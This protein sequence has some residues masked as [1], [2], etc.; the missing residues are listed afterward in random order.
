[1]TRLI[2]S[3]ICLAVLSPVA[4]VSANAGSANSGGATVVAGSATTTAW[5]AS[6]IATVTAHGIFPGT[7]ASFDP[8]APLE[9]GDL[10]LALEQLGAASIAAAAPSTPVSIAAL[11]A[12]VV[13]ALGLRSAARA[14]TL[15]ADQAGLHPPSR[16]GTEVVARLL[17][18]RTNLPA[19]E[20]S[21]ELQPQQ[22]ATRADAAFSLARVLSLGLENA[23]GTAPANTTAV[24]AADAGAGVQWLK[25][26]AASFVLPALTSQQAEVLQTAVSLIGFPYVWG[27]DNEKLEPGFDCSGLVWRVFKLASYADAPALSS[28]FQGRTA[29]AMAFEV[30]K[31][32]RIA[33]A[34]LEPGDV[35]FFGAGP[36][37]TR[38]QIDHSSIYL[39]NGWLIQAS[40]QGVSLG[41]LAWQATTF[42]WARR[43]LAESPA[44]AGAAGTPAAGPGPVLSV[45][46]A[47]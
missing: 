14:F 5:A 32:E 29:A 36:K 23:T 31:S 8:T 44:A 19:S 21:L 45:T 11:D 20:D 27:G 33:A 30:P 26:T 41:Q 17:G 18:L 40:G 47:V 1:M 24:A 35:L 22:T 28:V 37:S 38:A 4:G 46:V 7:P 3:C 6:A 42:A 12:S 16:F 9:R 10:D 34:S 43:P 13:Q 39:G 15:G 2:L 25:S